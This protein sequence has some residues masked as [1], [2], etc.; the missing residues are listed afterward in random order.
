MAFGKRQDEP[1]GDGHYLVERVLGSGNTGKLQSLLNERWEQGWRLVRTE[2]AN[3][4]V[5]VVLERRD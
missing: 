2:T 3:D 4:L 1:A 5:L